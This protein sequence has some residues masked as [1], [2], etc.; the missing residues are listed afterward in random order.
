MRNLIGVALGSVAV[1]ATVTALA[2]N[3]RPSDRTAD[4]YLTQSGTVVACEPGQRAVV[5]RAAAGMDGEL[6]ECVT[7]LPGMSGYGETAMYPAMTYGTGSGDIRIVRAGA[8][9]VEPRPVVERQVVYRDAPARRVGAPR[10][11][12]KSA[13]IIGGSAGAGAGIGAAIGG[14]KGALI[15]AAIG[16]GAA[17]V[18]D[19]ATR[20]R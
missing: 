5:R 4:R 2:L 19:Q 3:A 20:R 16:G 9:I 18:Y 1:G 17:T 12:Q 11:W 15:G 6:I 8:P 14:K 7:A 10:S 13:L